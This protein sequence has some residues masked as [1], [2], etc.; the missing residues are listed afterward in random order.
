MADPLRILEIAGSLRT[1]SLN[2]ALLRAAVDLAPAG[3]TIDIF[4]LAAVLLYNDDVEAVGEPPGDAAFKHAV[5][6]ADGVL[7]APQRCLAAFAIWVSPS[8]RAPEGD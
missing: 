8:V 7:M 3:M 5:S 1:G 4:D 6:D 2:R